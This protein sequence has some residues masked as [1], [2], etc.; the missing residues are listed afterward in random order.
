MSGIKVLHVI[1]ED[2]ALYIEL[3]NHYLGYFTKSKFDSTALYLIGYRNQNTRDQ[4]NVEKIIFWELNETSLKLTSANL[5]RFYQLIKNE[6]YD[7]VVCHSHASLLMA[8]LVNTLIPTYKIIGISYKNGDFSSWFENV[9]IYLCKKRVRLLGVLKSIQLDICKNLKTKMPAEYIHASHFS[10]DYKKIRNERLSRKEAK[11]KLNIKSG[12]FI[13]GVKHESGVDMDIVSI[14]TAFSYAQKEIKHGVMV[15]F[16]EREH[17]KAISEKVKALLIESE[18][19]LKYELN[20]FSH[21]FRA[22]DGIILTSNQNK[23]SVSLLQSMVSGL[24]VIASNSPANIEYI[25]N[26]GYLYDSG[27]AHQLTH[28]MEL[29]YNMSSDEKMGL[30][31]KIF[32]QINE[33]Y[34]PKVC[35][36]KFQALSKV[37]EFLYEDLKKK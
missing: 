29:I 26:A 18:V 9:L 14:L 6:K 27:D 1:P 37:Q 23:M 24:P 36:A 4:T 22:F 20:G 35:R 17:Q 19:V 16:C 33:H 11:I 10:L 30:K 8:C 31:K 3:C 5:I 13:L 2:N 28:Y 32:A 21:Y 34:T 7:V 15:I 25:G 12:H